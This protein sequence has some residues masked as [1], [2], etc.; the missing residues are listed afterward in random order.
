MEFSLVDHMCFLVYAVLGV[1]KSE[2]APHFGKGL[3][4]HADHEIPTDQ[5]GLPQKKA[6]SRDFGYSFFRW[7]FL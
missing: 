7:F 1:P 3:Q 5:P 4:P 2:M 6:Y